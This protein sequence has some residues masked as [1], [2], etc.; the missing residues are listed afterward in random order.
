[1]PDR[2]QRWLCTVCGYIHDGAEPCDCCPVCGAT[3]DLF[4]PS[5]ESQPT[6]ATVSAGSWRCLNCEYVHQGDQPPE[7]CPICAATAE[8]FEPF[9]Q[10]P[11]TPTTSRQD[12]SV[13][14][15]GAGI[16]GVSAAEAVRK[17]SPRARITLL[18]REAE[19]P[20]YRLNLTRYLAGEL[21]GDDLPIHSQS[22]YNE[23][24][25][26]LLRETEVRSIDIRQQTLGLRGAEALAYDR[27]I[28]ALG[29][30]PFVP[31]FPGVNRENVTV[32]RTRR[33][34]DFILQTLSPDL[35]CVIIGGGLL[36]LEAAGALTRRQ[37]KVTLVEGYDWLMPQQLNQTAA[38]RLAKHATGLGIDFR[39]GARIK[40][41]EGDEQVR[42]VT[43][44]SGETL[45]AELVI[46]TAGIRSNSY[47]ARL[48]QIETNNGIVVN[49]RLQT[50]D[51]NIY[52]VGDVAEHRGVLYGT[53]GPS[54]FQGTIAGMNVAGEQVEFAGIP[55]ANSLKVLGYELF[56]IG[57]TQPL[58]GS[59][60]AIEESAGK[61]YFYFLFRD[62]LLVGAILLGDTR[63]SATVKQLIEKKIQCHDLLEQNAS[64]A[65]IHQLLTS[66]PPA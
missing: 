17:S 19:L 6:P 58:D 32:L 57:Q 23:Q 65:A 26:T 21:G 31:P 11:E 55:R 54:Q 14:I 18:S 46:I 47:I 8:H 53:W 59:Y 5:R 63:L 10:A 1:M 4:E 20:Y 36:G 41:L 43:L 38:G 27:L 25:I 42:G 24:N 40:Q 48:A 66:P 34:A 9:V 3:S 28:L 39:M 2:S 56:S 29:S 35:P 22:W 44:E 60:Q 7:L 61:H 50:D 62:S 52:A 37:A 45:A 64:G 12:L 30:H 33:D 51:A 15:A 16:A 13:V 49:N